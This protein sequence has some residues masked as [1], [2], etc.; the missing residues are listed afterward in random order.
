[1]AKI[2]DN[3]DDMIRSEISEG[4]YIHIASTLARPNVAVNSL[5]RMFKDKEPNF[6]ISSTA[7]VGNMHIIPM[8]GICKKAIVAFCGDNCL[9]ARPN[10][11]YSDLFLGN[12][13]FE[14]VQSSTL[15]II[16]RLMGGSMNLEYTT[17]KSLMN[18]DIEKNA[19]YAHRVVVDGKEVM[20]VETLKPDVTLVHGV[21]A[22][23]DGNI[24]MSGPLGEGVW[25]CLA[26]KKGVVATVE[27]IISREKMNK[28][29][30]K[31]F[32]PNDRVIAMA[33]VP[34]GAYPQGMVIDNIIDRVD[35]YD[36]YKFFDEIRIAVKT[37]KVADY[38]KKYIEDISSEQDYFDK[39]KD[40]V[41]Y[42]ENKSLVFKEKTFDEN[43]NIKETLT[44]LTARSIVK[45]VKEHGYKTILAGIGFSHL[46]C[47][48]AREMLKEQGI[49]VKIMAELG[50]YGMKPSKGDVYLFSQRH[51]YECDKW[52]N[53]IE[54]LG[55]QVSNNGSCLGVVGAA[56]IDEE[57]NINSSVITG[58]KYMIGSGGANDITSV[59]DTIVVIMPS[60][61]RM[62]KH[63]DYVTCNGKNIKSIITPYGRLDRNEENDFE[64]VSWREN[65]DDMSP[66]TMINEK[67]SWDVKVSKDLELEGPITSK[68]RQLLHELDKEGEFI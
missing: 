35:Y 66:E 29:K 16:Q 58:G 24:V 59:T 7:M 68:E 51:S 1:M 25:G 42:I 44:I 22:D 28:I 64:L 43:P 62:V 52:S 56:Q 47:W 13:P 27:K 63:V 18:S 3:L 67:M 53:I 45:K 19:D 40:R 55:A 60:K 12:K 38:Y 32:I 41:E 6:T 9:K 17:T 49:D 48:L 54:I 21:C 37:D 26:A 23:E 15:S 20:L 5:V 46:A 8:S 36:D 65:V 34:Y 14:I 11:I 4:M 10:K 50:F 30:D 31:I 2:Y 61:E 57:G 33:E 39:I